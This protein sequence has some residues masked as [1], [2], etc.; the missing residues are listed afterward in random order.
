MSHLHT[1]VLSQFDRG[2][3]YG[4]GLFETM[5]VINGA[6][7]LL[8]LHLD[9]LARG[10]ARLDIPLEAVDRLPKRVIEQAQAITDGVLKLILTRGEGGRG[11]LA[12]ARPKPNLILLTY[13]APVVTEALIVRLCQLR[14]AQQPRLAGI[15]HLNRL[16]YVLARAEWDDPDIGEGLLQDADGFV[17][18]GVSSNLFLVR[19]GVLQ[20]PALDQCGVEGV[21][22]AHVMRV[23]SR[24][25]MKVE[26]RKLRLDDVLSAE[27]VFM[28]NSL[29]GIRPVCA[30]EGMRTWPRGELTQRLQAALWSAV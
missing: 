1:A 18:E 9:R 29:T 13:P 15:K 3:H 25:G 26:V 2:L 5:R 10:A 11:Y 22:R 27:E 23:A 12:P 6:V 30:I 21:M 16:E 8:D 17:I 7:R 14:L 19:G 4:D 20:T 24:L 28:T